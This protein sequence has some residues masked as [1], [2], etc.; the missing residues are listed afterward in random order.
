M[1]GKTAAVK[2]LISNI[3]AGSLIGKGGKSIKELC[4]VTAARV[5]VSNSQEFF[6]GT[7]DRVVSITGTK[8]AVAFA[9]R[10]VWEML[11][12]L[13]AAAMES[14]RKDVDWSPEGCQNS[15]GHY[16]GVQ[17]FSKLAIP[18]S[19]G[20][21]I[22]GKGGETVRSMSAESGARMIM[23]N[24]DEARFSQERVLSISGEAR[25]CITCC[26]LVIDKLASSEGMTSYVNKGTSYAGGG[27][28][29]G[30][31]YDPMGSMN[32]MGQMGHGPMSHGSGG[33]PYGQ[34][35]NKR[36]L[37]SAGS[38]ME[39]APTIITF[40]VPDSYVGAIL[41]KQGATL[42]E[43]TNWSGARVTVSDKNDF[44][45]GTTNR[46]ITITGPPHCAQAAHHFIQ[47]KLEAPLIPPMRK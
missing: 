15:L 3:Q 8:E 5:T 7:A 30:G 41:G 23:N 12:Q 25:Q 2:V 27:M 22:L 14:E 47:Q 39:F 21:L 10:L 9:I 44:M 13:A 36:S 35:G 24:K 26:L 18:S 31:I 19:A 28:N 32:P 38:D 20:G 29:G 4:A 33:P 37:E 6:P 17:V 16:G 11:A 42:R 45:E 43:I 34:A 46:L 1:E 40:G